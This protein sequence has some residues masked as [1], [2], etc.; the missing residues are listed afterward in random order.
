ML[1]L[2][3]D[4]SVSQIVVALCICLASIRIYAYYAPFVDD[5]DDNLA[6]TG[7]WAVFF[8]LFCALLLRVDVSGDDPESQN[9]LTVILM[10]L[11]LSPVIFMVLLAALEIYSA[12][13]EALEANDD[14]DKSDV[15]LQEIFPEK[16]ELEEISTDS[17]I[18]PGTLGEDVAEAEKQHQNPLALSVGRHHHHH[19]VLTE[20][21]H[22]N[23]D[24]IQSLEGYHDL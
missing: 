4:G 6:E 22:F 5:S 1:V 3:G 23:R 15:E 10:V 21:G 2:F 7:Q 8:V 16:M 19:L 13:R 11:T 24:H 20:E 17:K 14:D 9:R 18:W 12:G